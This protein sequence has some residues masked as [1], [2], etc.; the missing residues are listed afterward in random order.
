LTLDK[1]AVG[2][3]PKH[4]SSLAAT[5][6]L[7]SIVFCCG[8]KSRDHASLYSDKDYMSAL[9]ELV[10]RC[11]AGIENI[12]AVECNE[13]E[14][15]HQMRILHDGLISEKDENA[16]RD[17]VT[18]ELPNTTPFERIFV[19]YINAN[20]PFKSALREGEANLKDVF[21]S[22]GISDGRD[23]TISDITLDKSMTKC[24]RQTVRI[25]VLLIRLYSSSSYY[26]WIS[27]MK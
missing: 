9:P 18:T 13:A 5:C 25:T 22:C 7:F 26:M 12:S 2:M 21:A 24:K 27:G 8:H 10:A 4:S 3:G 1:S 17:P 14:Y 16:P 19:D 6:A 15:L 11:L 23:T 20:K